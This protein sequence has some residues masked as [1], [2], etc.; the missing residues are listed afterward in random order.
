MAEEAIVK[1]VV[2]G[3]AQID[4]EIDHTHLANVHEARGINRR[5]LDVALIQCLLPILEGRN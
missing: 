3:A 1:I 2:V 5:R 4:G